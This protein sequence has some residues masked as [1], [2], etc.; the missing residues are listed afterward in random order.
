VYTFQGFSTNGTRYVSVIIPLKVAQFPTELPANDAPAAFSEQ[1][2]AYLT[3]TIE[4]LN[5]ATPQDF[6][7][8]LNLLDALVQSIAVE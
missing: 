4:T 2:N 5:A 3:Q 8:N 1:Y 6:T 7:P